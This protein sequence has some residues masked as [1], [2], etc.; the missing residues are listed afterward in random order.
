MPEAT[1]NHSTFTIERSLTATPERVFA[2]F[3]D[4]EKKQRWFRENQAFAV[5]E[6]DFR[7]GGKETSSFTLSDQTPFPG[8]VCTNDTWYLDIVENRRIVLAYTMT[9]GGRRISASLAT[10][11]FAPAGDATSLTFTE[12]AAFFEGADG[13]EIRK[14]GWMELLE[15]LSR[16][17][18]G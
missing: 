2:A 6:L 15:K 18:A 16:E 12:Q 5:Y 7:V 4:P 13:P 3:S 8:V 10:F 11:E 9:L 17:I 14:G 1:V